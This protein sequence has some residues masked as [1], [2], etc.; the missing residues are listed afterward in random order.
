MSLATLWNARKSAWGEPVV[1]GGVELNISPNRDHAMVKIG[2]TILEW[3]MDIKAGE[4][5]EEFHERCRNKASE[6]ES[7]LLEV[8]KNQGGKDEAVN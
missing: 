5:K 2:E 1:E 6:F 4:T 7:W 3:H 8:K